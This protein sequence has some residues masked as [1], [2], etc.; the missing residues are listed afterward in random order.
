MMG[1]GQQVEIIWFCVQPMGRNEREG[2]KS[3]IRQKLHKKGK[4]NFGAN[5]NCL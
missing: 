3:W 1:G 2:Q 5:Y 4:I